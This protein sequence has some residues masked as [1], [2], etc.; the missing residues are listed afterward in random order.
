[1][2][3]YC[4]KDLEVGKSRIETNNILTVFMRRSNFRVDN[5][6]ALRPWV[7]YNLAVHTCL[8]SEPFD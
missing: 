2:S 4:I 5:C 3:I 7:V 6:V 8:D 1:M